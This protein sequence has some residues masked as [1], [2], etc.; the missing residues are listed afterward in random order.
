MTIV[1]L[2]NFDVFLVAVLILV[3]GAISMLLQLGLTR[4]LLISSVRAVVQLTLLAFVLVALFQSG[5]PWL[6]AAVALA[7]VLFAGY[8][9]M[10]RQKRRLAAPWGYLVG[11]LAMFIASVSVTTYAL[12]VAID[13]SPWYSPR[14]AVPLLGM[15]L[16]NCMT[17][18]ALGLN[19]LLQGAVRQRNGVEAMLALGYT[20]RQALRPLI[21]EATHDGMIP[22]INSMAA[23]GLV[24]IPG[25]MT[26]QI[27]AGADPS[28]AAR[29]QLLILFMIA[30]GTALGVT[31]AVLVGAR[32]LTDPRHRLRLDHLVS[33][34]RRRP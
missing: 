6:T 31:T 12:T 27:L 11:T 30:G 33:A 22:I 1:E 26:G 17:G 2:S 32:R 9:A 7:M 23:T 34:G 3:Y 16:G 8:E 20:R 28:Q 18:V 21:Q 10:A 13:V 24:F 4:T 19:A 29:Y 14:F 15:V 5:S 25:M